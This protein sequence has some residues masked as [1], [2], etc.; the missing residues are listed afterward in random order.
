MI[1]KGPI[2]TQDI[3]NKIIYIKE[4]VKYT[5]IDIKII[6]VLLI[7]NILTTTGIIIYLHGIE[8]PE[9]KVPNFPPIEELYEVDR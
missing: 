8:K 6:W 4:K 2:T 9:C 3:V 1:S 7:L 5:R